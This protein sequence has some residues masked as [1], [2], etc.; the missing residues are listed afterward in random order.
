MKFDEIQERIKAIIEGPVRAIPD[1]TMAKIRKDIEKSCPTSKKLFEEMKGCVPGGYEHQLAIN[2]PFVL[3]MTR[4][5]GSKMWDV[6][7]NEYTDWL[8]GAG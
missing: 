2:D 1:E 5:L 8:S 6:D 3:T 4:S 7:S